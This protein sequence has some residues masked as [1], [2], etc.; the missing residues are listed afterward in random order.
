MVVTQEHNY[1]YTPGCRDAACLV[2]QV[3]LAYIGGWVV[4]WVAKTL[5]C[6]DCIDPQ[7]ISSDDMIKATT[8]IRHKSYKEELLD[9]H[10]WEQG[11]FVSS[12][13]LLTILT[14][15]ED[16]ARSQKFVK[17]SKRGVAEKMMEGVKDALQDFDIFTLHP[18]HR[19]QLL[20]VV[21]SKFSRFHI[22][23]ALEDD[24]IADGNQGR[25]YIHRS[26]IFQGKW[27]TIVKNPQ[28]LILQV[29][30]CSFDII[31]S[32]Y[33]F[34]FFTQIILI[35]WFTFMCFNNIEIPSKKSRTIW[36]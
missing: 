5:T 4:R 33:L 16:V 1:E 27:D 20:E 11:L 29:A 22:R 9:K 19:D 34:S 17:S 7:H 32:H 10:N 25:N 13:S 14:K 8:L 23:K 30:P 36:K 21:Q 15:F 24:N 18:E 26:R 12:G 6:K 35:S 2:C 28:K 3:I 31:C